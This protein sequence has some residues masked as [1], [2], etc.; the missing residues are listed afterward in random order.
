MLIIYYGLLKLLLLQIV[1]CLI[2]IINFIDE[3][4]A[5]I[6]VIHSILGL[7]MT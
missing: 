3:V 5:C 2:N 1:Y 6:I 4:S 7:S